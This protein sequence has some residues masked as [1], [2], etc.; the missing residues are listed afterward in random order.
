MAGQGILY[1]CTNEADGC[2]MIFA[3]PDSLYIYGQW[4]LACPECLDPHIMELC[5]EIVWSLF[6]HIIG[7][8]FPLDER[9]S[10]RI[11]AESEMGPFDRSDRDR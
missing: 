7:H 5:R 10:L 6:S 4:I 3:H 9:D 2:E 11:V 1:Q 8:D